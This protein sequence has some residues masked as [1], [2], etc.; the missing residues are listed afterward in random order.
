VA[1]LETWW[2]NRQS[3]GS[4]VYLVIQ[5]AKWWLIE[6]CGVLRCDSSVECGCCSSGG[7]LLAQ[8]FEQCL[9]SSMNDA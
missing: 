7:D 6:I 8:L 9:K 1:L 3:G 4:I 2:L 5:L